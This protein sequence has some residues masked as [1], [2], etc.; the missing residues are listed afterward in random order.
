MPRGKGMQVDDSI[1]RHKIKKLLKQL[2]ID[3]KDFVKEETGFLARDFAKFTPPYAVFPS[4]GTSIGTG[5]DKKAGEFA[6]LGDLTRIFF[7]PDNDGVYDWALREFT[8]GN[9]YKKG[10]II[11]LGVARSIAEMEAHH[12]RMRNPRTGRI[13]RIKLEQTLWV[14]ARLFKKYYNEEKKKV[15]LSK[16]SLA[17]S[18]VFFNPKIR[19]PAWVSRHFGFARGSARLDVKKS[20]P[21]GIFRAS[22]PGLIHV[23]AGTISRVN[24]G[25]LL[26]M[27]K[28]L[29][30][31][32]KATARRVGFKA[33]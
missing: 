26:A 11:G 31:M 32:F 20:K 33:K 13:R 12:N 28:K 30:K 19:V 2:N 6:I 21:S 16:A 9:I 4:R 10:R 27:D 25:R 29:T 23:S 1:L 14:S 15:G 7:V 3:E 22:A 17:K 8:S 5:K 24:K 18:A